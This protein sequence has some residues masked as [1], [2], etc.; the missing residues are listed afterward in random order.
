MKFLRNT[1]RGSFV[2]LILSGWAAGLALPQSQG[3]S[4]VSAANGASLRDLR[5]GFGRPETISGTISAVDPRGELMLRREGPSEPATT[6]LT[7]TETPDSSQSGPRPSAEVQTSPGPGLTEYIFKI[8]SST[9]IRVN[10]QTKSISDLAGL[11]DRK[12]TVRF[13]PRRSGNFASSI[14][15]SE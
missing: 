14:D 1:L 3:D 13:I 6:H 2:V 11:D 10:G 9:Q 12:A 15:V 7:V 5:A 8:T 4:R